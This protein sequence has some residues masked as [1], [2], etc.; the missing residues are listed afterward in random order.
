MV[1]ATATT[2]GSACSRANCD[3]NTHL[4]G[5]QPRSFRSLRTNLKA[6]AMRVL[7]PAKSDHLTP[8]TGMRVALLVGTTTG[9]AAI[10]AN[11]LAA[12]LSLLGTLSTQITMDEAHD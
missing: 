4:F 3:A 8:A 12:R 10:V 2:F 7:I 6:P 1:V 9:R 11:S 5:R